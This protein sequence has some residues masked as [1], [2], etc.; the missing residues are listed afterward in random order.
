MHS[1][2]LSLSRIIIKPYSSISVMQYPIFYVSRPL[3]VILDDIRVLLSSIHAYHI[4]I[5]K[6]W[7]GALIS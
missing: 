4:V 7:G 5:K 3:Y 6:V 1:S 2:P